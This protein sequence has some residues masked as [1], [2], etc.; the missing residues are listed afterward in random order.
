VSLFFSLIGLFNAALL[1]PLCL[2]LYFTRV[3]TLYWEQVPWPVLLAASGLSLGITKPLTGSSL[4]S[5]TGM[6]TGFSSHLNSTPTI[7]LSYEVEVSC[8]MKPCSVV[9]GY[10]LHFTVKME[11]AWT[12]ETL[13]SYHNTT[14]R[15]NLEVIDLKYYRREIVKVTLILVLLYI[16]ALHP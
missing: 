1:W 8:V 2:V 11:A 13:I 15:H 16:F 7:R 3:E 6:P 14:R 12:S 9:A 4:A 10:Q 5:T